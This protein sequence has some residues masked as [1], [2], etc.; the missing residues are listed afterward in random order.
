MK[1]QKRQFGLGAKFFLGLLMLLILGILG[2]LLVLDLNH[3]K[4]APG[5]SSA[6]NYAKVESNESS[7]L[8][9]AGAES[10]K[11][12]V[13]PTMKLYLNGITIGE[14]KASEKSIKYSDNYL[15]LITDSGVRLFADVE[16]KTRGNSTWGLPKAPYQIK[17][18]KKT[19]LLGLGE[20]K[21]WILLANYV[22][23]SN[24]R[25]DVAYKLAAMLGEK[26]A[27]RGD[28]VRLFINNQYE[29]LYYLTNK[30]EI[31]K[32]AVDLRAPDGVLMEI[33]N[34]HRATEKCINTEAGVCLVLK[35]TVAKD[36]EVIAEAVQQF[37]DIYSEFEKAVRAKD[38][39][40]VAEL[41]DVESFAEYF[42]VNEFA[43]NPDAYS[44]SFFLYR[45]GKDDKIHA[46]PV[47][48]FDY[49]F[50]NRQ[51]VWHTDERIFSPYEMMAL[52]ERAML[53][54]GEK[55]DSS[56]L[57]VALEIYYLMEMPEFRDEVRRVFQ[58]KLSGRA[59]ELLDF[60]R[61][62]AKLIEDEALVDAETWDLGDFV[63]ETEYLID[64]V[65]ERY[66]MFEWEYG[67]SPLGGA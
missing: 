45:D 13:F 23:D 37:V 38:Y 15:A 67:K 2:F 8:S 62:R 66:K 24:L 58:T 26:Y 25:N 51:W 22:D 9:H 27:V 57:G 65:R 34:L 7:V 18:T 56:G 41:V 17:F 3:I 5:G 20:V 40:K 28:F 36:D 44:S 50:A 53:E 49:A 30:I 52:L 63:A 32:G 4:I 59:E 46:G 31:A 35:D 61:M 21:E 39:D 19:H 6:S 47:W 14:L 29:G 10:N 16:V 12:L 54:E 55:G 64:W 33:D 43:V 48:D 11:S 42:L 1:K 60:I